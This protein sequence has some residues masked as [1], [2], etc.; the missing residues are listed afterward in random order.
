[1]NKGEYQHT[2]IKL[3]VILAGAVLI[4]KTAQL[5][6][7]NTV[8]KERAARA[9]LYQHTIYPARG[10]I[11]DRNEKLLVTN[12]AIYDLEVIYKEVS[13]HMDTSLFCQ[14][15]NIEKKEFEEAINKDWRSPRF[16]KSVAF[17]ML[18]KIDPAIFSRF[19]EHLYQ[20]PGFYPVL[21]NV[22]SYPH[23]SGAHVLGYIS[24]VSSQQLQSEDN[25]YQLGDYIGVSGMEKSYEAEL[26][27][28]KGIEYVL[29]DNLGREVGAL[30]EGAL[31]SLANSGE[32]IIASLDLE[33]QQ[34]A[35]N[36]MY[37]K[38]G[39]VIALEP[40][41]GEILCMVSAPYYD[42]NRLSIRKTRNEAFA[43]LL[44]DT[45]NKPFLDRSLM[46]RYPPGSIFK[47]ILSLIALQEG[48]L[49]KERK[50][51]CY[52]SY[53]VN[54]RR[55]FSQGCRNH[56]TPN[57]LESALQ[58]SCNS[59][60]YQ[61][62]REFI[63]IGGFTKPAVGL[64]LLGDYLLDFGIGKQLG[65]DNLYENQGF[66]PTPQLYDQMYSDVVNGWRSTYILSLG[67][68]QGELQLTTLQMANLAAILANRGYYYVPHLIKSFSNQNLSIPE[69]FRKRH[70][71]RID[72]EHFDPVIN[73][74][75]KVVQ[76]GTARFANVEGLDICGKT[77]TSQNPHGEDHSVFFAFAP[78]DD[79]QIAVAVFIEN[80]GSGSSIAAPTG[81]LIIQKYLK[82]E[83][84]R[85]RKWVEE[86]VIN[87]DL[88]GIAKS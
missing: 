84:S 7:F 39:S 61:T 73:G 71:V 72:K 51:S 87:K 20:F 75:A 66:I 59:Y 41:T 79:P 46:A 2:I 36:L 12:D 43:Q 49:Q 13:P 24:E 50:M 86:Y 40:K 60:F 18:D 74:M 44:M 54:R 65:V 77:G 11:F 25:I 3:V 48:V 10:L 88:I 52:G 1:M 34:F 27:G 69:K 4:G 31:D 22:R 53:M 47:P 56:P 68:G 17:T 30:A 70:T 64:E 42:P 26:R 8:L 16:S 80:G 55:G 14:L 81:S 45:L 38:R 62:I 32:D 15:L 29:K 58:W 33:L 63:E 76:A 82:G 21:R 35:E 19:Q 85:Q 5:Q 83:I 9:T 6:L 37:N 28:S 67:I 23:K 78:K 57:D